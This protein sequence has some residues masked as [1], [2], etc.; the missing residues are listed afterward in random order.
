MINVYRVNPRS[1]KSLATILLGIAVIFFIL[2]V[3]SLLTSLNQTQE[4]RTT[5][6]LTYERIIVRQ[7]DTL[8]GIAAQVNT[9]IDVNALVYKTMKYNNLSSTYIQPGQVIYVPVR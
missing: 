5:A 3:I 7:G 4:T 2:V 8:W 9:S 1:N 6:G